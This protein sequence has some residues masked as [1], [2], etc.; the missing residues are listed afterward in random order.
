MSTLPV[1][2]L[3]LFL[4]AS[5]YIAS[6]T[7]IVLGFNSSLDGECVVVD[8]SSNASITVEEGVISEINTARIIIPGTRYQVNSGGV[9]YTYCK[10]G[11]YIML[12]GDPIMLDSINVSTIGYK[13]VIT[14]PLISGVIKLAIGEL[15]FNSSIEKLNDTVYLYKHNDNLVIIPYPS[16]ILY[17]SMVKEEGLLVELNSTLGTPVY[18]IRLPN[19]TSNPGNTLSHNPS[20]SS[21]AGH[22]RSL[23]AS[24]WTQSESAHGLMGGS[25]GENY[26]PLHGRTMY[27]ITLILSLLIISYYV[28][29]ARG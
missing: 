15:Y 12:S 5:V 23:E 14:S 2:L 19:P 3:V 21:E 8:A 20:S 24:S 16:K 22:N 4:A 28:K 17:E 9:L 10:S 25:M 7:I 26:F 1:I 27:I 29:V 11:E 6:H 18:I 13:T